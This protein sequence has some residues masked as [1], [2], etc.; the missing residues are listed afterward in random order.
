MILDTWYFLGYV[1]FTKCPVGNKNSISEL[2]VSSF[3]KSSDRNSL[4]MIFS[5]NLTSKGMYLGNGIQ[6]YNGKELGGAE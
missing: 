4:R 6:N 1:T 5:R 3:I 2:F